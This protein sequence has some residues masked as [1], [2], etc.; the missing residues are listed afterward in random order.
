MITLYTKD[1]CP[2]CIRAKSL[3][4]SLGAI[5]EEVDISNN[6]ELFMQIYQKSHMRTVPQIFVDDECLGGYN[7]IAEMHQKG[8][9]VPRIKDS[10]LS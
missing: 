4:T 6:P 5:Y 7:E 2:Y 10:I 1:Y 8:E 3:L 9:L